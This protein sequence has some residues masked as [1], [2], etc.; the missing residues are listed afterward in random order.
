MDNVM[1]YY[2]IGRKEN[3]TYGHGS[4]GEETH[5]T[6][7]NAYGGDMNF[8]PI[9]I[10]RNDANDY[11]ISLENNH[12]LFPVELKLFDK[13]RSNKTGNNPTKQ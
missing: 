2:A 13:N 12:N 8:H 3:V 6:H 1:K 9:F 11:I 7:I 10:S 4:F 5:I